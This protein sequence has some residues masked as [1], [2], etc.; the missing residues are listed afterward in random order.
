MAEAA[1]QRATGGTGCTADE[2]LRLA[3]LDDEAA[4]FAC[5][6]EIRKAHF[7]NGVQL[8]SIINAK[9]GR[10]DMDCRFCSQSGRHA[11]AI[12]TY[13]FLE[14]DQL[15]QRIAA[16][17]ASNERHCGVVTS[18]GRLSGAEL[19][20]LAET[21][22]EIGNG[23]KT[24]V[25]ASTGRLARKDLDLLKAAGIVRF[26]HNLETSESFYPRMCTTQAWR[27]RLET[28]RAAQAAGL[29]VCCGGLFGLGESWQDR[30]DLALV[31]RNLGI[32]SIPINFLYA[33]EGTPM[34]G[35]PP[36]AA[37]EALRIV[38][39]LRFLLPTATLRICGGRA[40]V[41]GDRQAELFA[42]GANG[43]MTGDYLTV[44]GSQYAEDLAMVR[45]LGLEIDPAG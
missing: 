13:P 32:R 18:G 40:H 28:V 38:A 27:Q 41:L 35:T 44:A 6:A 29:E 36:L 45:R 15:K 34:A 42:A 24:P 10:C 43:L 14:K 9:S 3:V 2:A 7:G 19:A 17:I 8:C 23:G 25:C 31:L 39:V 20:R 21:V 33:H 5:A 11:T 12:E 16:T 37:G 1:A 22:K 26:H 4:L 30:I